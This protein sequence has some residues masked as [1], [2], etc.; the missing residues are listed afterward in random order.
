MAKSND[1]YLPVVAIVIVIILLFVIVLVAGGWYLYAN[2]VLIANNSHQKSYLENDVSGCLSCQDSKDN[3]VYDR[4]K[5][6][7]NTR[8]EFSLYGPK[9][10]HEY[11]SQNQDGITYTNA[12]GVSIL[13]YATH[14]Y[15]G[16]GVK[17]YLD[18]RENQL[19]SEVVNLRKISS[20]EIYLNNVVGEK[21]IWEYTSPNDGVEVVYEK[22][23]FLKD[24]IFYI[25]EMNTNWENYYQ[26]DDIFQKIM[27]SLVF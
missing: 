3:T 11:E 24:N 5:Y 18:Q 2:R 10:F 20:G 14:D 25:L 4:G 9:G 17:M 27:D 1:N 19:T 15:E 26:Y 22:V 7:Y 23:V 21:R 12:D 13:V 16:M 6:Y 8:Y